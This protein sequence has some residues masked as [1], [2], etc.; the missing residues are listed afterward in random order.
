V[1]NE[2]DTHSR[3]WTKHL[4]YLTSPHPGPVERL[5][6]SLADIRMY[7]IRNLASSIFVP[8]VGLIK[9]RKKRELIY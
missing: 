9:V 5:E 6:A 7:Q 1:Q 3:D 2:G 4:S 8:T